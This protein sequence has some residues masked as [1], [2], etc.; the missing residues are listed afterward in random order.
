MLRRQPEAIARVRQPRPTCFIAATICVFCAKVS[1]PSP[2]YNQGLQRLTRSTTQ[3]PDHEACLSISGIAMN[4]IIYIVGL[5]VVVGL[6]L[7]FF[8]LR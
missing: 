5:V 6:V 3:V 4:T 2:S 8:G 7:S 1:D